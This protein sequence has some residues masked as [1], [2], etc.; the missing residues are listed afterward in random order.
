M[1]LFPNNRYYI[2]YNWT[3]K[4][5]AI[6]GNKIPGSFRLSQAEVKPIQKF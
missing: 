2:V 1:R 3:T 4:R 5:Y 6:A